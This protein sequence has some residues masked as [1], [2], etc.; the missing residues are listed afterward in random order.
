[1]LGLKVSSAPCVGGQNCRSSRRLMHGHS[2]MLAYRGS[3]RSRHP[4]FNTA[5]ESIVC[6]IED[7]VKPTAKWVVLESYGKTHR[8]I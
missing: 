1:M 2:I 4:I 6:K 3:D 8:L 5:Y 7:R